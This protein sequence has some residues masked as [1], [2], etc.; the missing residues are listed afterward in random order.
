[1][2]R[3]R[4]DRGIG[5]GDEGVVG[6]WAWWAPG[7]PVG[8]VGASA[9]L[10]GGRMSR[11]SSWPIGAAV[12]VGYLDQGAPTS[13]IGA[14]VRVGYPGN[15]DRELCWAWA[16]VCSALRIVPRNLWA[17]CGLIFA[18]VG[19]ALAEREGLQRARAWWQVLRREAATGR[20]LHVTSVVLGG[21]GGTSSLEHGGDGASVH[22]GP[23]YA[24]VVL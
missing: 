14:E 19:L 13:S 21:D 20:K 16:W 15:V 9:P 4:K 11:T 12:C 7:L 3:W 22:V 18:A 2:Q 23:R 6:R 5:G 24:S 17:Q 8:G 10:A 1:M